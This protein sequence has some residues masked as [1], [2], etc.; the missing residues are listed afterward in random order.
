[1][2]PVLSPRISLHFWRARLS[3]KSHE[4]QRPLLIAALLI[5][6]LLFSRNHRPG[7]HSYDGAP[8]RKPWNSRGAA[9]LVHE[10]VVHAKSSTSSSE[11]GGR[12]E[13]CYARGCGRRTGMGTRNCVRDV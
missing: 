3:R 1:M 7:L 12:P 8:Q 13:Y 6:S 9:N 11:D 2:E 4:R 5:S 10:G